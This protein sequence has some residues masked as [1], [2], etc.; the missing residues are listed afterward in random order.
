MIGGTI[1]LPIPKLKN[2]EEG[3]VSLHWLVSTCITPS[4]PFSKTTLGNIQNPKHYCWQK[5]YRL[6]KNLRA[7]DCYLCNQNSIY[8][9]WAEEAIH[10]NL[11]YRSEYEK[12][13]YFATREVKIIQRSSEGNIRVSSGANIIKKCN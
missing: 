5:H 3:L 12:I 7:N 10:T 9:V 11:K 2:M 13:A 4:F 8:H 6:P 1:S